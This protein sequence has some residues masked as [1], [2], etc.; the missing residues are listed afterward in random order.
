M[1]TFS[2]R[3][4]WLSWPARAPAIFY[5]FLLAVSV[6]TLTNNELS[7]NSPKDN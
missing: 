6:I 1:P 5:E 7:T 3:T 4:V 2:A